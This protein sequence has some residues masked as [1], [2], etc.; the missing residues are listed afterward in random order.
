MLCRRA[1]TSPPGAFCASGKFLV[2]T[3]LRHLELLELLGVGV[4]QTCGLGVSRAA[5]YMSM[6]ALLLPGLDLFE[7]M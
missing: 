2:L 3:T 4:G 1:V 7:G 5:G 6:E